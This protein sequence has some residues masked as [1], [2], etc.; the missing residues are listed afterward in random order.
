MERAEKEIHDIINELIELE[1]NKGVQPDELVKDI[2]NNDYTKIIIEKIFGTVCCNIFFVDEG[3]FDCDKAKYEYSYIYDMDMCLKEIKLIKGTSA[4]IIWNK[5]EERLKLIDKVLNLIQQ[6]LEP[7]RCIVRFIKSLPD[8]L[9][10][11]IY[12]QSLITEIS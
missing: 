12:E 10:S 11:I 5:E 8:N 4:T 9:R 2:N 3:I 1:L 6:N 7:N